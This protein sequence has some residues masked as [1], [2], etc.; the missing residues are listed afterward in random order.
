MEKDL[1]RIRDF[2]SKLRVM[3]NL[4]QEP[5]EAN[6]AVGGPKQSFSD[7]YLPIYRQELLARK[8]HNFVHELNTDVRL[9]E[10]RQQE[11]IQAFRENEELL[12]ST[13]S[14]WPTEGWVSSPFGYRQSPFTAKREFHRGLDISTRVGTPIVA[15][16]SGK[17][18]F[19]GIDNGYGR[20]VVIDHGNGVT[21][22]YA[23]LKN[24]VVKMSETVERGQ[25]IAR[26]GSTGR[27]TGPHLHYEVRLNGLCV[28]PKRYILN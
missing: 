7:S 16:A 6:S 15:P 20:T 26:V 19:T 10:V 2:D 3:M 4:D 8:M 1:T 27:S 28:N 22:R 9:E 13:P 18:I 23:H 25:L 21:T 24:W 14:I 11:I 12:S 17:V 5:A